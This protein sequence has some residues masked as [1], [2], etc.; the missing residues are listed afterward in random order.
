MRALFY[1]AGL[2]LLL[3]ATGLGYYLGKHSAVD[4]AHTA[5]YSSGATSS[6]SP[7]KILYYRNPMGL[8]DTSPVPKLDSMGMDY[9]PV[10][11]DELPRSDIISID[12]HKIQ[13]LGVQTE[14][15]KQQLMG[16]EI[17]ALGT[18][19]IDAT[20]LN[21]IS[22]RFAGWISELR[23][24]SEGQRIAKGE[25]L[26]NATI[27]NLYSAEIA[28]K[29]A[30]KRTVEVATASADVQRQAEL[31]MLAAMERLEE[32]GVPLDEMERLQR[33]GEA[34]SQISYRS[35][36]SGIVLEKNAVQGASFTAG[37]SLYRVADLTKLWLTI[38]LPEQE[39]GQIKRGD[40]LRVAIVAEPGK[41][42]TTKVD[43]IYP[44]LTENTRS[45]QVRALLDNADYTL[46]PGQS[47]EVWLQTKARKALVIPSSALLDSGQKQWV[48]VALS[49]G[50]Y[51][52]RPIKTGERNLDW[53]EI[54]EGLSEGEQ[55]VSRANFL[56]DSESRLQAALANFTQAAEARTAPTEHQHQHH[57]T[58]STSS[59][60]AKDAHS[61]M[62]H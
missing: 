40:P 37:A 21:D 17:R 31:Q 47:A 6:A 43:F 59:Q 33:G 58:E 35:P 8:A 52:P 4:P 55:V 36:S 5:N 24:N 49:P 38:Q 23:A 51:Q 25:I 22:P 57:H 20:T 28:Y 27:A 32:I 60:D 62:E 9:L 61:S 30:V 1:P 3:I 48:L 53:I 10:Y 16:R 42:R 18:L 14:T 39:L 7:R 41:Y 50:V 56:I 19:E 44:E 45:L 34:A 11:A 29:Q 12:S 54:S 26:F 46:K 15:V 2:I 13:T